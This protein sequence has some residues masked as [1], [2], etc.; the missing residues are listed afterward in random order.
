MTLYQSVLDQTFDAL[1]TPVKRFHAMT[2]K[3]RYKGHAKIERGA[4]PL[5]RLTCAVIGFPKPGER[6][7]VEVT[8]A[9]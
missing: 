2:H 9:P 4:H 7:P 8:I 1:P 3:H 5:A 6:V